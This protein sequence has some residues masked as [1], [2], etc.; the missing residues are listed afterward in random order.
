MTIQEAIKQVTAGNSLGRT[1]TRDVFNEIMSGKATDAQ[2][3]ALIVALR[4]KGE[5]VDEISGA[6]EVMR[7]KATHVL[8]EQT[9]HL[10]DTCGTG[11]DGAHTFNIST[12]AAFAA[13]GAGA[14]VAKHGN[15]SVSSK[16][17]SADVLEAMGVKIAVSPQTMKQCLDEAGI[18]FLFAPSLH[19]AMKYAIG[20]RKEIGVRTIF[21]ILG[22]LTNPSLAPAQVLGVYAPHLARTMAGVL[23]NMGSRRAFVVHGSDGLD[24]I[25]ITGPTSVAEVRDGTVS[26]YAV[27]PESFG[28]K[29][30]PPE[31]VRGG[32]PQ[33]NAEIIRHILA[34]KPGPCRDIT[35]LNAAFALV[36]AGIAATPAD[37]VRMAGESIDSGAAAKKLEM[38]VHLTGV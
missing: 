23:N 11:G 8:P 35:V 37:G 29:R 38:L 36:A 30:S 32:T 33:E 12:A 25:T 7:E 5:T 21:N 15:R 4:M 22:P 17:G 20:P 9:D 14:R 27:E 16:S 18:C 31:S 19:P 3:A 10:V 28:I 24:E 6:A 2:I 26:T 34:G 1:E 13:A